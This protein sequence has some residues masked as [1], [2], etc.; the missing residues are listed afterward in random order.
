MKSALRSIIFSLIA[1]LGFISPL[2]AAQIPEVMDT[3]PV[4]IMGG[5][6][7]GLTSALYLS[8]AGVQ[9]LVIEGPN[10]GGAMVQSPSVQ[11][12][13]GEVEISGYE[14]TEKIHR[15]VELSG[16]Q[17]LT[18]EVI[19]V[20]FCT[21]PYVITTRSLWD[22]EKITKIK[23]Q[24][25]IIALGATP[26][27]LNVPGEKTFWSKGVYNCAVCDGSLYKDKVVAVVG[28]GESAIVEATHLSHIAKKVY[29]I[30]RG[31]AIRSVEEMRKN[32]LLSNPAVEIIYRS[33]VKEIKG[34]AEG[35]NHLVIKNENTNKTSELE[36]DAV[37]LAIG[38]NPNS[39]L[40]Q[41]MIDLDDKGYVMLKKE[42]QTSAPGVFAVGDIADPYYK[43]AVSAAGDGA[44]AAFQ[45]ENYLAVLEASNSNTMLSKH[46]SKKHHNTH[47]VEEIASAAQFDTVLHNG[48]LPVVIDFYATWCNPCKQVGPVFESMAKKFSGK[49]RVIKVNIENLSEITKTYNVKSVPTMLVFD[50]SGQLVDRRSGTD[51]IRSF[52]KNLEKNQ[53]LT[54]AQLDQ[55]L[56]DPHR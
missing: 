11:N 21:N 46:K 53:D 10:P 2:K 50:K 51:D 47:E 26:K 8:R 33:T 1:G 39:K 22:P 18:E 56:K 25:V 12:W 29:V 7:G 13:P 30:V 40:F 41:G 5:G 43:Q 32:A 3:Y 4:V 42:Q 52:S 45:V 44:K 28:G 48:S 27:Y 9:T 14:L 20:D 24:S 35:V 15:Q 37:F 54:A 31:N 36:L 16:T 19:G 34:N 49:I 38:S 17:F 23:A 6:I 55:A